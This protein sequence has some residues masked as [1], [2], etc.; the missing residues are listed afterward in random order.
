M[1]TIKAVTTVLALLPT[2]AIAQALSLPPPVIEGG[3]LDGAAPDLP[4]VPAIPEEVTLNAIYDG[5]TMVLDTLEAEGAATAA[6][7]L[8]IALGFVSAED[9]FAFV[10]DE[11][12]TEPYAG[13]LRAPEAVLSARAGNPQD[14]A[15]LL[16]LLLNGLGY[17]AI[18]ASAP[19]ASSGAITC[20]PA[21]PPS[22]GA[23]LL[24][25]LTDARL[26]RLE[27]RAARDYS[28]L[29]AALDPSGAAPVQTGETAR[30]YWVEYDDFGTSV[31]FDPSLPDLPL[32]EADALGQGGEGAHVVRIAIA[33]ETLTER[34]FRENGVLR[35]DLDARDWAGRPIHLIFGPEQQGTGGAVVSALSSALGEA[36][37]IIATLFTAEERTKGSAF[38]IPGAAAKAGL[39]G[40]D[41]PPVTAVYLDLSTI[42]PDGSTRTERRALIDLVP[43]ALR[44][45]GEISAEDLLAP[46][47]TG[48]LP[49]ALSGAVHFVISHGGLNAYDTVADLTAQ[50]VVLPWLIDDAEAGLLGLDA[51]LLTGWVPLSR[52]AFAA[53][54]VTRALATADDACAYIGHPRVY[55]S[56]MILEGENILT[57]FD[58][59][60]DG[61]SVAGA[62]EA[63]S[64]WRL[65]LWQG[66]LQAALETELGDMA[67]PAG[68]E[69]LST[70]GLLTP[71]F[72]LLDEA[73]AT[74]LATAHP[75]AAR[76][77][78]AGHILVADAAE[79]SAWWR[80][81]PA[82]GRA[83]ARLA[84][85]GNAF[86][87]ITKIPGVGSYGKGIAHIAPPTHTSQGISMKYFDDDATKY[88]RME[89]RLKKIR[90]R[91]A[92]KK[93]RFSRR[94]RG[95]TEYQVVLEIS[96]FL[97]EHYVASMVGA[98][99][100]GLLFY[101]LYAA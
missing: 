16:A 97:T 93:S 70:S 47:Q 51:F 74:T 17:D 28:H 13:S 24:T 54:T 56:T 9:A 61:I 10:R 64:A 69:G 95:G 39:T 66:A 33:A 71:P 82:T 14:K 81:D 83:D 27:A 6:D 32:P 62:G 34:G 52:Q 5:L 100:F 85:A 65:Q 101:A 72:T 43:P 21:Q 60:L 42:A 36:S 37:G 30:R 45:S 58:W 73:E 90:A 26:T 76:D 55:L 53:E 86:K 25:G 78:A 29:L 88:R 96:A 19:L 48:R 1:R 68:G 31:A 40:G 4:P 2:L 77:L 75:D 3:A 91:N 59:A 22:P 92:A 20:G 18:V 80:V 46:P 11:I 15:E 67:G 7:P 98:S 41:A 57:T 89:Q 38:A 84:D 49:D 94:G 63:E 44:A 87:R 99:V 8:E 23:L 35:K 50:A 12:R 79:M